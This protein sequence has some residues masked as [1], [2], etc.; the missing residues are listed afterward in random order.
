MLLLTLSDSA[1]VINALNH[2]V[3]SLVAIFGAWG[4]LGIAAAILGITGGWKFWNIRRK[5]KEVDLT[6]RA[7]LQT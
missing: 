3:Q 2:L 6:L 5:D 7:C 4:T 1:E